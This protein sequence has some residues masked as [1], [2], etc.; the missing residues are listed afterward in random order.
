MLIKI[1]NAIL[2]PDVRTNVTSVTT[3]APK[4][5]TGPLRDS[6]GFKLTRAS[7]TMQHTL[8]IGLAAHG[9]TRLSWCVLRSVG[10]EG[11][12]APS[13]IARNLGITRPA[14]SRLLKSMAKDG[15]IARK[16]SAEDGRAR[17]VALTEAG[18]QK[19]AMC[20]PLA[21]ANTAHFMAKLTPDELAELNRLL[22]VLMDGERVD[23]DRL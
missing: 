9:L 15:L 19:L 20:H 1:A 12:R 11:L 4:T 10:D 16:L 8:E 5:Q 14:L 7:R 2:E 3:P 6:L 21:D 17:I 22:D 13:E 18:A 23:L